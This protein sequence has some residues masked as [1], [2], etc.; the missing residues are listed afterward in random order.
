MVCQVS[1]ISEPT[2]L[3]H[4]VRVNLSPLSGSRSRPSW[5]GLSDPSA[6]RFSNNKME[7]DSTLVSS[8]EIETEEEAFRNEHSLQPFPDR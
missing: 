6:E 4:W 7:I 8:H 2:G 3:I 1:P 5:E